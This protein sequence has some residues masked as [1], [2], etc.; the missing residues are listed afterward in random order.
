MDNS[1]NDDNKDKVDED[2]DELDKVLDNVDDKVLDN[3]DDKEKVNW[4]AHDDSHKPDAIHREPRN[5][6]PE[7]LW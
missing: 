3:N 4:E 5:D 2:E 1:D 6:G 7:Y